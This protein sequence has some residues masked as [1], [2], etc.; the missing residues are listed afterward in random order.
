M[1][2]LIHCTVVIELNVLG[3]ANGQVD[4]NFVEE[5]LDALHDQICALVELIK[6]LDRLIQLN[7]IAVELAHFGEW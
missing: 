3:E 6:T 2:H 7:V 5:V 1:E 4:L